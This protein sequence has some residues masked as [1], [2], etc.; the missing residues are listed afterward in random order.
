MFSSKNYGDNIAY[1]EAGFSPGF[2]WTSDAEKMFGACISGYL[3]IETSPDDRRSKGKLLLSGSPYYSDAGFFFEGFALYSPVK[4]CSIGGF[5][6]TAGL[7]GPRVQINFPYRFS[8][9]GAY[10]LKKR[11]ENSHTIAIGLSWSI[12]KELAR[13]KGKK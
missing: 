5:I 4:W 13:K 9:W 7:A 11:E 3:G 10:D 1:V 6:Q 2:E 8:L 12:S